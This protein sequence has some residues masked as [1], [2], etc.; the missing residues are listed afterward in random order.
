MMKYFDLNFLLGGF[1]AVG[2]EEVDLVRLMHEA[3][4]KNTKDKAAW[5]YRVYQDWAKWKAED[6]SLTFPSL[7]QMT[8]LDLDTHLA[9]FVREARKQNG[10]RYPGK[11]LHELITC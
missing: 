2:E 11:T 5:A 9:R 8:D 7:M 3:T 1:E 4:P 6:E 10:D